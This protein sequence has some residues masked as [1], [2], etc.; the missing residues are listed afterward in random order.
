MDN[1]FQEKQFLGF[2]KQY[3]QMP[4]VGKF[5]EWWRGRAVCVGGVGGADP[6]STGAA[7]APL[8]DVESP[9]RVGS[10]T[11]DERPDVFE[12]GEDMIPFVTRMSSP[13]PD[14]LGWMSI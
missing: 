14:A 13:V 8:S 11:A 10:G 7:G 4:E 3:M 9:H 12:Q 5:M 1:G 2:R 6:G